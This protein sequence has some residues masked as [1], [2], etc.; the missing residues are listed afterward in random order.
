M[1]EKNFKNDITALSCRPAFVI[2]GTFCGDKTFPSL[3]QYLAEIGRNPRAGG[4]YKKQYIM[5]ATNAIRRDLKH[6]HTD[7]PVVLHYTFAEPRKGQK[8]DFGNIFALADKFVEDA[9]R[10]CNIIPDDN[11]AYVRN[12][13]HDFIYTDG[14]PYI[15][16]EIEEVE[17]P[18][19]EP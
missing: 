16:V 2:R 12:F 15:R 19:A 1:Q 18:S 11:P 7:K 10:D 13:T 17:T 6:F 8:R 5:I 9:L 14:E 3:N 4:R